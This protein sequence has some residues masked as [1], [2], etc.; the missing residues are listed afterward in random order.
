L[1]SPT[2][3]IFKDDSIAGQKRKDSCASLSSGESSGA[4]LVRRRPGNRRMGTKV[5]ELSEKKSG[6]NKEWL[7][8]TV[9]VYPEKKQQITAKSRKTMVSFTFYGY[10]HI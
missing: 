7:V 4:L 10:Q 8:G 1:A 5:Q 9:Q 3:F 2:T 6:S